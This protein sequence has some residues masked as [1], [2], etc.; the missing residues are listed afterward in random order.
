MNIKKNIIKNWV[1]EGRYKNIEV[2]EEK[3]ISEDSME[4]EIKNSKNFTSFLLSDE[5]KETTGK[6]SEKS[7]S[8]K[9]NPKN[10]QSK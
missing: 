6:I 2:Y 4:E 3:A 5:D 8:I 9:E 7:D 1:N 10:I